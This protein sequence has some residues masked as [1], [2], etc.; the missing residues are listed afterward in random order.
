MVGPCGTSPAAEERQ[1][2]DEYPQLQADS[3]RD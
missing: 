2:K 1:T 3:N